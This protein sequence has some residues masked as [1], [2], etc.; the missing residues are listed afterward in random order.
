MHQL[1]EAQTEVKNSPDYT[2]EDGCN[3]EICGKCHICCNHKAL[4]W[5]ND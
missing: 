2:E 5:N 3:M 4:N 1:E